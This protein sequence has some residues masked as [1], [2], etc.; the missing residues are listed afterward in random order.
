M[1][2]QRDVAGLAGPE[3]F[4]VL[5]L[6]VGNSLIPIVAADFGADDL[7]AVEPMFDEIA[8]VRMILALFHS[9]TGLVFLPSGT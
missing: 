6:A 7:F 1:V 5:E 4:P 2:L 3:F 9:P 8:F